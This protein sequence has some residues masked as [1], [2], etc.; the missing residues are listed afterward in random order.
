MTKTRRNNLRRPKKL[1][2][3]KKFLVALLVTCSLLVKAQVYNN[4][5]IDYSKTYYKFKVAKTGLYRIQQ[6]T[7]SS[8]GLGN[9][10][11]ENF[12]LWRNGVQVPLYI[13]VAS[14]IL[15]SSDYIEF[16]GEMNDGKPDKELYR[17]PEYQL[18]ERWSLITD[19][20]AYFLTVS[21]SSN[22][23]LTNT[24][25][26]VTGTTL[27]VEPYFMYTMGTWFKDKINPGL[28]FDVSEFLYSS[29]YDKGEGWTS[30][31][32]TTTSTVTDGMKYDSLIINHSNLFPYVSGPQATL[33]ISVSGNNF[34][35]RKLKVT[36]NNDSVL[37]ARVDSMNYSVLFSPATIAT[38]NAKVAITN[39]TVCSSPP[40]CPTIDR[41]VVHKYEISYPRLFNFGGSSNFDFSLPASA[42][43][44]YLQISNFNYGSQAPVL[45]DI[46]N[47]KRYVA[48][49]TAAPM[50]KF[51]MESSTT[52]RR[53]V[54]VNEEAANIT[55][56]N[57][58]E[59]RNFINYN[60]TS[61]RGDYL[62]I[63][64][65][66][67]FAGPSGSNPVEDYRA[68]RSSV[69]GGS[70]NA[71]IY[72]ADDLIDQFGFGIRKNPAAIR[73]FIRYA[74]KTFPVFPRYVFI[75]GKGVN[76][77][78]QRA[79]EI[80]ANPTDLLNIGKLNLVPTYGWPASDILLA[81]EPGSSSPEIPIGRMSAITPAEVA[82]YLKKV[83]DY[84]L[85]QKTF[86]P[87]LSDKNWM[88]NVAHIVGT[89]EA[90]LD[91]LLTQ[92]MD[93]YKRKIEDTLF[94]AKVSTFRKTSTQVGQLTSADLT[95]L[96]NN[97]VSLITYFG[98]SA[99]NVLDFNLDEP[100]NY[101]NY[102]KYPLFVGLGCNAG[103]FFK[104]NP[105][106]LTEKETISEKYVLAQDRGTIGFIAST[107]FGVV[108]YL[109]IW[110]SRFYDRISRTDYGKPIGEIMKKTIE[111]VFASSPQDVDFLARANSEQ[112][113][114][115]GDPA[116]TLN[117]QPKPDYIIEDQGV[118]LTPSF[119]SIADSSF[120]VKVTVYNNGRAT[121]KPI[122][123]QVKETRADG[124]VAAI[125]RVTLSNGVM[126][127]DSVSIKVP[128]N[129]R[130]DKGANKI[131]VTVDADNNVDEMFETNNSITK[132][133]FI[134]EDEARPVY[135]LNLSIVNKQNIKLTASTAN[136]M[137][138][139]KQY[140]MEL[141]TTE[142]FNSPF[143]ITKTV[144][145][146]GGLIEFDPG[147]TFI[148]STVYYWRVAMVPATGAPN[149]NTN[150]FVY[151]VNSETG[152][153]QSHLFQ[154]LKSSTE[155]MR[156]DSATRQWKFGT[157][158]QN[159]FVRAGTWVTSSGQE[160]SF[161]VAVNFDDYIRLACSFQSVV[162]NV[163]NP[164]TLKPMMNAS[165]GGTTLFSSGPVCSE[166]TKWNFEYKYTDST[167]R[168][169][170]RDFMN[171]IPDGSYVVVR[172]FALDPVAFPPQNF[173][174][175]PQVFAS[176]WKS[177]ASIYGNGNTLYDYL[178]AA[179]LSNIDSFSRPR[180]FVLIYKKND[181]SFQ[182]QVVFTQG[183]TDNV[184]LS[185]DF[186]TTDSLGFI[187]SP[188]FGPAKSWKQL[189]WRGNSLEVPST[190]NPI[191]SIIGIRN[192]GTT[193]TLLS[194]FDLSKQTVDVTSINASIYPFLQLRMRNIDSVN[195]SPYQLR[196]WRLTYDPV[197]EG[198]VAPNITLK[199]KDTVD[200]G[201][202]LDFQVGF[203]NVSD[204]SFDSIKV[205]IVITDKNN[206][207]HV[208]PSFKVAKLAAGEMLN[209]GQLIDTKS[210]L[211]SNSLYIELNPDNDQPELYHFNNFLTTT[212]Y[213]RGDTLNPVMDVTFDNVHILNH[214]I[215]SS[216]P[217]V[218]IKLKDESK[219][220]LLNDPTKVNVQVKYP[221]GS[222]HNYNF[223]SDTLKFSPAAG[224]PN[225]DN[226]ATID[227]MPS[228]LQDGEYQLIVSGKDMSNNKAGAMDYTV[229]FQVINK[230][231]I[232]NLLNYPNPFTTFTSFVFT[233]TGSEVPQNIKIQ[234]LTVTGKIVREITKEELGP[235]HIGRNITEFKWDGT[236]QYGQKLGNGVY[237]YHVVTNLNGH[238]LE[239]YKAK[240]D[241]T[242]KYFTNGYGKMYLM[243]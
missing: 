145:S 138:D 179:G 19:T 87:V 44:T 108:Q 225:S 37:G 106:R 123:V 162:F 34:N 168:R 96:I 160:G 70:Y 113:E 43:G 40:Y 88:K 124:S 166:G 112:T 3:M 60:T 214:D 93:T 68:Y 221:D 165:P 152:F 181:P 227:F 156:M 213:V 193:S 23:R 53:L 16:W 171:I 107:H 212:F 226:T 103:D 86:S 55:S 135:P 153:N 167:G 215:V 185:V 94:G 198:A 100:Q 240:E 71:K 159:L 18:N 149:W 180:Q 169:K 199:K 25:N 173:P 73:N 238:S 231:M 32:I 21:A 89:S 200:I 207:Q 27:P 139:S 122:V 219:W 142:R 22:L 230:A 132:D 229:V 170:A 35:Q 232:S 163:F 75:I 223:N 133:I 125:Q 81:S 114:L 192:D 72:S 164:V 204:G 118:K 111:D 105:L 151:L 80:A 129:S 155:R 154:H 17:R 109:D 91:A 79:V 202:P 239:K 127:S 211:G 208:L 121:H 228:F 217:H 11:A 233:V 201:E 58:L 76:Y 222:L 157:I 196:Y 26:N 62:I 140:N 20:A 178:K 134:Y 2:L 29:S 95:N 150:S 48:D 85:A 31:D 1:T 51:V 10:P 144:T 148:D 116:I 97:G 38:G 117:S 184:T 64:N 84:E 54:L 59:Q 177:D 182:P 147:I 197:P 61:N 216:R 56:I 99:A 189:K 30:R 137:S 203:K 90:G 28:A 39:L 104:Y 102:G 206:V 243:R 12:Q 158:T 176:A 146:K 190:D 205:K 130:M 220:F 126:Y 191:V 78:D 143:K 235:I 236:D 234:V 47:G 69:A 50:L 13:S 161:T 210:L 187:T 67:L 141:D 83:K 57:S 82:L 119:I 46:T 209:V 15:A 52:E 120:S 4:E 77:K 218:T 241:N 9:V 8:A 131:T 45:Y 14:G 194:N 49:I 36:I 5:W 92:Y 98:H 65:P 195:Y 115:D 24:S 33:K 136:P 66:V 174:Q 242:D 186:Q 237:L 172:S 41:L 183:T 224:A 101:T 175:F 74:R 7:L 110:N 128:V 188:Q 63:T 6:T 42:T